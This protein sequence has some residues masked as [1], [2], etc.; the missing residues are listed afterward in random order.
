MSSARRSGETLLVVG[1]SVGTDSG[2]N[3]ARQCNAEVCCLAV[4]QNTSPR[5]AMAPADNF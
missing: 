4:P 5:A 2:C 3:G 1:L